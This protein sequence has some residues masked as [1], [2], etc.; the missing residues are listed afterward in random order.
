MSNGR[1]SEL[2]AEHKVRYTGDER[3]LVI[4]MSKTSGVAEVLYNPYNPF[5]IVL[6]GTSCPKVRREFSA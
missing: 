1:W 2:S 5:I 3:L 6:F 4:T